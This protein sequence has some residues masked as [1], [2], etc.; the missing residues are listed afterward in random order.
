MVY[1]FD[2][3][4]QTAVHWAAKRNKS[5]VIKLLIASGARVNHKDMGGRTALFLAAKLGNL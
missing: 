4:N 2:N 3:V 1:E 5:E